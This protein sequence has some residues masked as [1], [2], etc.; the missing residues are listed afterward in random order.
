M[1]LQDKLVRPTERVE[2]PDEEERTAE[3]ESE[4]REKK[5]M[6]KPLEDRNGGAD[7]GLSQDGET[8]KEDDILTEPRFGENEEEEEEGRRPRV[9]AAAKAPMIREKEE[10]EATHFPYRGWCRHRVRGR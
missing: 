8:E 1:P 5:E 2:K 3:E 7:R 10:H 9:R 4:Q 6:L